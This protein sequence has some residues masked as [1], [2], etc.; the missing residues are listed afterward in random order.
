MQLH[1]IHSRNQQRTRTALGNVSREQQIK[2]HQGR[3]NA[4]E[5][6]KWSTL[7]NKLFLQ[8]RVLKFSPF[9]FAFPRIPLMVDRWRMAMIEMAS[10]LMV[11]CSQKGSASTTS[12]SILVGGRSPFYLSRHCCLISA[13]SFICIGHWNFLYFCFTTLMQKI[14]CR[15]SFIFRLYSWM[16]DLAPN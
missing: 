11:S 15:H 12:E 9:L 1:Y 5:V 14:Y 10:T 16:E 8:N 3:M 6:V 7:A 13:A 2:E 4:W